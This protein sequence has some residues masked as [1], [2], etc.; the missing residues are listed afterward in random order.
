MYRFAS[1]I[2]RPR[3]TSSRSPAFSTGRFSPLD[4]SARRAAD[5]REVRGDRLPAAVA[6]QPDV[7]VPR[8]AALAV[9]LRVVRHAVDDGHVAERADVD[10][11]ET[12][13]A[14]ART[15]LAA[16]E[17][18]RLADPAPVAERADEVLAEVLAV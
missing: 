8:R 16:A 11:V 18:L 1:T 10:L 3:A 2:A 15:A 7:G 12:H 9:R 14:D 6:E 4:G 13:V 17:K 5:A